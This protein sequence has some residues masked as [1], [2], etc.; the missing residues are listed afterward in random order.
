V[1]TE[2]AAATIPDIAAASGVARATIYRRFPTR[3]AL[4][5]ALTGRAYAE[6]G[7]ALA[8]ARLEEGSAWDAFERLVTKL[9]AVGDRYLFLLTETR[10][11]GQ[12]HPRKQGL[13]EPTRS[14]LIALVE[15]GQRSGELR[16]DVPAGWAT[17]V[18]GNLI[19]TGLLENALRGYGQKETIR[20]V[21]ATLMGG[22][23]AAPR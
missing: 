15:R 2:N 16:L 22:L 19:A 12:H 6:V 20:L 10:R 13:E 11:G 21:L 8:T 14:Q 17:A 3:D 18:L 7:E 9:V 5:R 1:L 4:L 23:A